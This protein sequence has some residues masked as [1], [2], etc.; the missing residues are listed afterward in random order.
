MPGSCEDS[1]IVDAGLRRSL[2]HEAAAW[3]KDTADTF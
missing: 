1:A 3:L 2:E